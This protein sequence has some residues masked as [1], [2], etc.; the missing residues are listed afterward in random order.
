MSIIAKNYAEYLCNSF[1]WELLFNMRTPYKIHLKTP[2][3]WSNRILETQ[4]LTKCFMLLKEIL[5][6]GL[7]NMFICY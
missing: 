6:T 2:R 5:E 7:I 3:T 1:N 4:R